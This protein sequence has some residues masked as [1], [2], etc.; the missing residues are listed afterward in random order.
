MA[1]R[2]ATPAVRAVRAHV[3]ATMLDVSANYPDDPQVQ[4]ALR[5]FAA[6]LLHQPVNRARSYARIG[7]A[8]DFEQAL[9]V[10]LGV[11]VKRRTRLPTRRPA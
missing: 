7:R 3:E 5:Q 4:R 10:F 11:A 9:A 2:E 1:E 8:A 6:A